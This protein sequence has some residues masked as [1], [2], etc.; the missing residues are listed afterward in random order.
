MRRAERPL[1]SAAQALH[2]L[3]L[4]ARPRRPARAA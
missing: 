2:Q 1:S 4:A 3:L